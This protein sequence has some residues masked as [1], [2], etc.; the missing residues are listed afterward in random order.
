MYNNKALLIFASFFSPV[1][2][3]VEQ[4]AVSEQRALPPQSGF[5]QED[6]YNSLNFPME[7]NSFNLIGSAQLDIDTV[8]RQSRSGWDW[9]LIRALMIGLT[10][11][12]LSFGLINMCNRQRQCKKP[13]MEEYKGPDG[14]KK[15]LI[16]FIIGTSIFLVLFSI[17]LSMF[18]S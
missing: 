2:F 15:V 12:A 14:K 11:R 7:F 6:D 13:L 18:A 8:K 16:P 3:F 9:P 1:R 5:T 10:L 4:M 17:T